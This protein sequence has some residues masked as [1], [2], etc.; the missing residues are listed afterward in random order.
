MASQNERRIATEILK[1]VRRLDLPLKLDTITE[2]K[3]N[4]FPLSILAQCKRSEIFRELNVSVQALIVKNDPTLLRHAVYSFIAKSRHPA[5]QAYKDRYEKVL[6]VID[7]KNWEEYWNIMIRNYEWVDYIFI[8]STAWYLKH[9]IIIV[10]TSSTQQ[11]PYMTI[12]GNL[13][14]CN[15][16]CPGIELTIGSKSQVHYQSLLPLTVKIEKRQVQFEVPENTIDLKLL[17]SA[18]SYPTSTSRL[19]KEYTA[20]LPDI[21]SK[22]EFPDLNYVK[23]SQPPKLIT[24]KANERKPFTTKDICQKDK[25][26][27]EQSNE[28]KEHKADS[29]NAYKKMLFKYEYEGETFEFEFITE[30]RIKCSNCKM[31]F[32]NILRHLQQSKC[33]VTNLDLFSQK[34]QEFKKV[35][36]AEKYQQ[37][38]NVRK[39]KSR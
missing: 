34:F 25:G 13:D 27:D 2:G 14:D 28:A 12:S 15:I 29:R 9:D 31:A 23:G 5:I 6:S 22:V 33:K 21:S 36:F 32:K 8:Q 35:T 30:S 7:Q 38:Q 24:V 37:K 10:T 20:N 11:H 4:C 26:S 16:P 18:N 1:T 39:I 17:T 3:G 19:E